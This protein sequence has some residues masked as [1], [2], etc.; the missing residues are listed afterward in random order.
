MGREEN[1]VIQDILASS[2]VLANESASL[3]R[4][5]FKNG[6]LGVIDK[7]GL[8]NYQ[9][10]ADRAVQRL[11]ITTLR[12]KFPDVNIIGEED[13]DDG[14]DGATKDKIINDQDA[15]VLGK[16]LPENLQNVKAS[17]VTIWIDPLD[18]TME[19]IDRLLHHVT[20]LIGVAVGDKAVAGVINQPFFG[21]D[22]ES[23]KPDQWG[24]SIWGVVGLGSFG[25]FEQKPLPKDKK[26]ICTTRSHSSAAVNA[27]IEAMKPDEVLRQGGAG[28]KV[29]R[30]IEGDAHAYVFASPGTKKW[31]TCAPEAILVAMGGRLTDMHGNDLK[32]D[33]K[34]SHPNKGGV[35][36]TI[37]AE[38]QKW[39]VDHVPESVRNDPQL[40][41]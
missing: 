14:S 9:T 26:I 5:I 13:G 22:D 34:V 38:A 3:V 33:S 1:M 19:F 25:P 32:Y 12:A 40:Q 4:S 31:D 15:E 7:G 41:L 30:V 6:E 28:N 37:S 2:V 39:Y 10:E 16:T 24:R 18:G 20:I 36:A 17:D 21:F 8:K 11:I 23:K 27:C 29:L 35:L